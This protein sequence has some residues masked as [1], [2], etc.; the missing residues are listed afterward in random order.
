[1]RLMGFCKILSL[2]DI[3]T[4][5]VFYGLIWHIGETALWTLKHGFTVIGSFI[6]KT[7]D[8]YQG[9]QNQSSTTL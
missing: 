2:N 3:M 6:D 8:N 7:T 5:P 4:I 9:T 1:M